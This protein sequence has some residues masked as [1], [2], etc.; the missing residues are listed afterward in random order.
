MRA[1]IRCDA[2][3]DRSNLSHTRQRAKR[4]KIQPKHMCSGSVSLRRSIL[5]NLFVDPGLLAA[6]PRGY[7]VRE[8]QGNLLLRRCHRVGSVADVASDFDA[9]VTTNGAGV[10]F[11]RHGG[12]QHL[13]TILEKMTDERDVSLPNA[14][15]RT[16]T[17]V[18]LTPS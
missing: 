1:R 14:T 7:S 16:K 13:A 18:A 10:G 9:E 11:R 4:N 6:L 15:R 8:P 17:I 3:H 5:T 2:I 12:T